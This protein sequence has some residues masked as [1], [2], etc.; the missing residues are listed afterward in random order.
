[1]HNSVDTAE[2]KRIS[3]KGKSLRFGTIGIKYLDADDYMYSVVIAKKQGD[4]PDRNKVKRFIRD[5]MRR[6]AEYYPSGHYLV[7]FRGECSE[8]NKEQVMN[9]LDE[10]MRK[11]TFDNIQYPRQRDD[12]DQ[13]NND[14][15]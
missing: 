4:S 13:S 12:Y 3:D 15:D 2:A 10:I 8:F 7:Y 9:D 6:K 5:L 14:S 1:M 11:I